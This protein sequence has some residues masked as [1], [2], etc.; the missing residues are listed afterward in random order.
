MTEQKAREIREQT[1]SD[2]RRSGLDGAR[3]DHV[4]REIVR[5]VDRKSD[6]KPV[7]ERFRPIAD[8]RNRR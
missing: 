5:H 8:T 7:P 2:L 4:A 6:G 1:A 3:A